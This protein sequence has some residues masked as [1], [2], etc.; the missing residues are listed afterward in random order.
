MILHFSYEEL[1]ALNEGAR[2]VI[3]GF[4]AVGSHAARFLAQ[5]KVRLVGASDSRGA[6]HDEDGIDVEAALRHKDESGSVVG[7]EDT[8]SLTGEELL[9]L[10]CDIL[11]PAALECQIHRGNADRIQARLVVEGANGPTTP[12]ADRIL[13]VR[14]VPVLPDILANAGGVIVSYFEWVQNQENQSWDL[15]DVN[16]RL[17]ERMQRA[18]RAVVEAQRDLNGRLDEIQDG[19]EEARRRH[20]VAIDELGPADLRT[21]AYVV[22]IRRLAHVILARGLWP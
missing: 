6:I 9:E 18:T 20:P 16:E 4:G 10:P 12:S 7:L 14:G 22:A 2:A 21:A 3:Q 15:D 1:N 11:V 5:K 8:T 19:L 13:F 17:R